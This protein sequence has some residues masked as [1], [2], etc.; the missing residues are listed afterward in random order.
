MERILFLFGSQACVAE[1]P[2]RAAKTLDLA[3]AVM[4]PRIPCGVAAGLV[5]CFE[6]VRFSHC[7]P[8]QDGVVLSS[9]E[10]KDLEGSEAGI[11]H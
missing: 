10:S 3:T 1:D 11:S 2:L 4:G 5:D 9:A 6:R 7:C 8:K